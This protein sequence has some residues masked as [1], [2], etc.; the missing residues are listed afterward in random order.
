[1]YIYMV[2]KLTT[3]LRFTLLTIDELK[4]KLAQ[5]LKAAEASNE[6]TVISSQKDFEAWELANKDKRKQFKRDSI[7][8]KFLMDVKRRQ[9]AEEEEE[10]EDEDDS[11]G[12]EDFSVE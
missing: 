1:M 7:I 6:A 12:S 3:L 9:D 4:E 11:G 10:E 5:S 8:T 2:C